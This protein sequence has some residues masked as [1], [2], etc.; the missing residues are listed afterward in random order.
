MGT[1]LVMRHISWK[2]F[3]PLDDHGRPATCPGQQRLP[4]ALPRRL[5]PLLASRATL[6]LLWIGPVRAIDAPC[7]GDTRWCEKHGKMMVYLY[8]LF[9]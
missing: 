4:A 5:L 2:F 8:V 1:S 3:C 7:V 9:K 6:F